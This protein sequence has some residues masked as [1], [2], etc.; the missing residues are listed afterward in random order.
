[1]QQKHDLRGKKFGRW[2]VIE[3]SKDGWF[4]EC[5]CGTK[6]TVKTWALT[7]GRSKSCGCLHKEIIRDI[8]YKN[9]THG[10]D[11][12]GKATPEYITWGSMIS[13][14]TNPR[15]KDYP[16]YLGRGIEVCERW[17]SF[18]NF[19]ADMG[20]KP[21][22]E[23]TLDRIDNNGNYEPSNCRWATRKEQNRNSR[24]NRYL[25]FDGISKCI[26]EWAEILGQTPKYLTKMVRDNGYDTAVI[27]MKLQKNGRWKDISH[28]K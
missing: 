13:R 19:L 7:S 21:S 4:C 28:V 16:N 20:Y 23:H 2:L 12:V 17:H 14:C 25:I 27:K 9:A 15:K 24:W 8:G 11:R 18:E 22:P 10:C 3:K 26:A 5:D 1:M 6:K